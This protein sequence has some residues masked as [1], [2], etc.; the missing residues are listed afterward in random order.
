MFS[1]HII[2]PQCVNIKIESSM[3]IV[4]VFVH[5]MQ[6]PL[7][8]CIFEQTSTKTCCYQVM[9]AISNFATVGQCV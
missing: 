3:N 8:L 6:H 7:I 9:V 1:E 2:L 5:I 4:K